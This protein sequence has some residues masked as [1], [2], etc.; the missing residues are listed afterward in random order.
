MHYLD[1]LTTGLNL[2]RFYD[3]LTIVGVDIPN[4]NVCLVDLP[5]IGISD[6]SDQKVGPSLCYDLS[7]D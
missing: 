2:N 7:R 3:Y 6:S 5:F 1:V 4:R